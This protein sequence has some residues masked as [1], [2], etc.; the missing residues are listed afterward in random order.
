MRAKAPLLVCSAL[1][2]F[3][4]GIA[5]AEIIWTGDYSTGDVSQWNTVEAV[6]P[7]RLTVQTETAPHSAKYALRTLV[8]PGDLV[9]NGNRAELD[10]TTDRPAEGDDRYYRWQ[11][12][13]PS[14]FE[15]ADYWQIF[16][17]WHQYVAGGSPPLAIMAWGQNI[18]LGNNLDHYYWTAPLVLGVWHDFVVHVKWSVDDTVGG[19][20]LWYDGQHVLPFTNGVTL[21]PNDTV[22]LKQGLYRNDTISYNQTVYHAGMQ[23][24][25]TLADVMPPPATT[26]APPGP[27]GS[28]AAA[29]STTGSTGATT[30]PTG[31]GTTSAGS[32]ATS[33]SAGTT[34]ASAGTT[35]ASAGTT[36][37]GVEKTQG[38]CATGGA[39]ALGALLA[40]VVLLRR[41]RDAR[42]LALRA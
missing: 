41:R 34:S 30:P 36:P 13:F 10:Y 26:S 15:S 32:G 35:S 29:G 38:G 39:S 28:A 16:T 6:A 14:D 19:V 9:F 17:Q 31:P 40:G 25:T 20:E 8:E 21:F 4:A 12:M 22:Y 2:T 33:V 3:T 37:D 24:G 1:A 27:S 11:T 23:V 42:P 5:R 7:D 18:K